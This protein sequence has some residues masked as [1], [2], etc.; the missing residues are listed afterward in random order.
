M[1]ISKEYWMRTNVELGG[2]PGVLC[3][4][5][6]FLFHCAKDVKVEDSTETI[7]NLFENGYCYYFARILEDAFPGGKVCICYPFGHIVYVYDGYAYD[8]SG[9]SDAEHE[10][11]IPIEKFGTLIDDFKYIPHLLCDA[12]EEQIREI[13]ERCK[14]EGTDVI[15]LSRNEYSVIKR[16]FA[17]CQRKVDPE[18]KEYKIKYLQ[19]KDRIDRAI[20]QGIIKEDARHTFMEQG[21]C[22][23][24]LSYHIIREKE[25][26]SSILDEVR[27]S[28]K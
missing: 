22:K 27:E 1:L 18:Y 19:L 13:G 28:I 2:H 5:G 4:I 15:A 12:T 7:R 26:A 17:I 21:C 6:D 20:E 14:R 9:I 23:L 16:T 10:C 25:T 3:F 11:Y 24:G 8:I